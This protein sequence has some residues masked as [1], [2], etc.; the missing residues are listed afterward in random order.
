[1]TPL[2]PGPTTKTRISTAPKFAPA[3]P[4]PQVWS[5]KYQVSTTKLPVRLDC[6]DR[7]PFVAANR[8][9]ATALPSATLTIDAGGHTNTFWREHARS[10]LEWIASEL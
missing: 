4:P 8:A 5:L 2:R 3:C 7:D 10:Q 6:G 1:M 9:F